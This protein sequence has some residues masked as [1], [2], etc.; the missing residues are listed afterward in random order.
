[1]AQAIF[2]TVPGILPMRLPG[3]A[4][5]NPTPTEAGDPISPVKGARAQAAILERGNNRG[6]GRSGFSWM[7]LA[8]GL[9]LVGN[10]GIGWL[11]GQTPPAQTPHT[12]GAAAKA[13]RFP[14]PLDV[15][16]I[17]GTDLAVAALSGTDSVALV[18]T[19]REKLVGEWET[20]A[21]PA[22]IAVHPDGKL[23]AVSHLWGDTVALLE[24]DKEALKVIATLPV[25]HMPR[26]LAFSPDGKAL[27]VALSGAN[28]LGV[29]D[30]IQKRLVKTIPVAG[31]PRRVL[32][33]ADGKD[34]FVSSSRS[35]TIRRFALPGLNLV[36]ENTF[37]DAFN[38]MGLAFEPGD[39]FL[40]TV[41]AFD[42][43]HS[44]A[45]HNIEQGW[46]IDNRLGRLE[47]DGKIDLT[48]GKPE[49]A[50]HQ[51]LS[52]DVRGHASGDLA[53]VGISAD[54]KWMAIAGAGT[55]E[56]FVLPGQVPWSNGDPGDFVDVNLEFPEKKI[57][58]VLLGGRP[59]AIAIKGNMAIIA[60]QLADTIQVVDLATATVEKTIPLNP[61]TELTAERR[62]EKIFYDAR[63]SHHQWFSCHTCH[64]DGHT[65]GRPFD[66]LADDSYGNPK[67]TP[68]LRGVSKTG[69][70]GW[71]GAKDNL[72]KSI[73]DS[74]NETLFGPKKPTLGDVND[75][76]A[77]LKTLDH[78][79]NPRVMSENAKKGEAL[80]K[81]KAN[82]IRCH[83]GEMYTTPKSYE[84]GLEGD[85]S[86]FDFWNPPSLRGVADRSP[87]GHE[88]KAE[89]IEEFIRLFHQPEKLGG[90]A[91]SNEERA[92]IGEFLRG[93]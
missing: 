37:S 34:L 38:L 46:A 18:D 27:Y 88:G 75:L 35:A 32:V 26:G 41:Q 90:K 56:L 19:A 65:N 25:G 28:A 43:H 10:L 69:P 53:A 16:V 4:R 29:I 84:V 7:S 80:F 73:E 79:K 40:I 55:Q 12:F 22:G 15:A 31:E 72:A 49:L 42:R 64:T 8:L 51:Q 63:R 82:C 11:V 92:W 3:F 21:R 36:W 17:P 70:W 76:V 83:N 91:I 2:A 77:F 93:L 33:S 67:V 57:R 5:W 86:P 48:S 44:I 13:M 81:G 68:T 71:H 1:M 23:I 50:R 87:L 89:T 20:G 30:P 58:Q 6:I 74:L 61:P 14:S 54:G 62:G 66:T 24:R 52:L 85:G 78:P 60:N 45:K 59:V 39:R 47:R 9:C